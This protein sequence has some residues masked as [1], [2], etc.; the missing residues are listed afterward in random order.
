ND[1]KALEQILFIYQH[2][3]PA[4]P[5]QAYMRAKLY[6]LKNDKEKAKTTLDES[7]KLGIDKSRI[8]N[9]I[10]LKNL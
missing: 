8:T 1:I 9:D 10:L 5:E 2:S 3:D 6:V 4:N 7:I